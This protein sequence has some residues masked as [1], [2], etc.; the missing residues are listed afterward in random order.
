[1]AAPSTPAPPDG[2]PPS[3]ASAWSSVR[4]SSP[5][6]SGDDGMSCRQHPLVSSLADRDPFGL[7]FP[8][9]ATARMEST[10][11]QGQAGATPRPRY[12]TKE[13]GSRG[14]IVPNP[15]LHFEFL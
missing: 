11:G 2:S 10:T 1:M 8:W 15:H 5:P 7:Q 14:P 12:P 9:Q 13:N 4:R 6:T 3:S